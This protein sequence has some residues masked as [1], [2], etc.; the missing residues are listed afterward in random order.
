M[1]RWIVRPSRPAAV[2]TLIIGAGVLV[3]GLANAQTFTPFLIFW[4]LALVAIIAFNVWSAFSS[5]GAAY[6]IRP[7]TDD[8]PNPG[9]Q[10]RRLN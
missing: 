2:L 5:N 10:Q 3:F 4:A 6:T 7:R 8:E 9:P 1:Q